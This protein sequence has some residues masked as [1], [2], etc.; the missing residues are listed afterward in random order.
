MYEAASK[1][2]TLYL[3]SFNI[4]WSDDFRDQFIKANNNSIFCSSKSELVDLGSVLEK[5]ALM[6]EKTNLDKT[7]L[8][9]LL[10]HNWKKKC[11]KFQEKKPLQSY[12][13]FLK[14]NLSEGAGLKTHLFFIREIF[15]NILCKFRV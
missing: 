15:I 5:T 1:A 11:I 13:I 4:K 8:Q 6:L 2:Q 12:Q 14:N 10:K 9:I 3:D 7:E